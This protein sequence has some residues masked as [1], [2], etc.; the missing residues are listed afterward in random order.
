MEDQPVETPEFSR[1]FPAD[2]VGSRE[3]VREIEA[4]SAERAALAERLDLVA[5]DSLSA[6]LR[7]RRLPDGLIRLSGRFDADVVQ[8][9]VVTLA[10]VASHCAA[11]FTVRYGESAAPETLREIEVAAEGEDE[12]EP[13]VGGEIDLGEAVVQQLAVSLD[14]YPRAPGAALPEELAGDAGPAAAGEAG[15][16]PFA[17]LAELKGGAKGGTGG[18]SGGGG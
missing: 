17:A 13:L 15:R 3:I 14:P 16:S 12:P 5:L 11:A 8:S 1:P 10:P 6:T 2:Q 7:L 18:R 9:C 4:S